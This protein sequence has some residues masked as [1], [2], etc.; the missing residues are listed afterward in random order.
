M[1]I[2]ILN[3]VVKYFVREKE[4]LMRTILNILQGMVNINVLTTNNNLK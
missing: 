3:A 4:R 1:K 2:N